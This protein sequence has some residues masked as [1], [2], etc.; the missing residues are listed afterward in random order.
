[1]RRPSNTFILALVIVPCASKAQ[2]GSSAPSEPAA[3]PLNITAF[4]D[5]AAGQGTSFQRTQRLVHWVNDNFTWSA[6]DYQQRTPQQIV[7]RR[8]GNCAELASV[9][10]MLLDSM[11]VRSRWVRE[12]N[13]QPEQTPRR[14]KTAEEKVAE[15]GNSASV[16]GLQH[17]DHAWL[18][19][20]D[21]TGKT[22]FPADP[23][24]GVVGLQEWLPA[25]LALDSRPKP[26]VAAVVPIAA[27]M[28]VLFVVVAGDSRRGPYVDDRTTYY[29]I[30]GFNELY[31]GRLSSL[32]AWPDWVAAIR[33]VSPHA[34]EAFNGRENLHKYTSEIG[35]LKATYD[36]LGREAAAN[37]TRIGG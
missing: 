21:D 24:F 10:R 33:N 5:S 13:V 25:R 19:V 34:V 26:R 22:W 36:E 18:E 1:M 9:L 6:T 20:W 15:L 2:V 32:P 8:T 3:V 7:A 37:G 29:L 4:A 27:D 28:L 12:I 16:F 11:H 31:G 30:D 17:N 35:Q 14:Q 23:A